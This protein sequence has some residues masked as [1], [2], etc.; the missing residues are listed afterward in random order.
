MGVV[1]C[2]GESSRSLER[3]HFRGDNAGD[4]DNNNNRGALH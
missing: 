1:M 4:I 2:I 3:E